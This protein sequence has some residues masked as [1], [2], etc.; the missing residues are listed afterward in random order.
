MCNVCFL[1]FIACLFYHCSQLHTFFNWPLEIKDLW[2]ILKVIKNFLKVIE[3]FTFYCGYEKQRFTASRLALC[4]IIIALLFD[5]QES[6]RF[7]SFIRSEHP[8]FFAK[9]RT[10]S[11]TTL[12]ALI[13]QKVLCFWQVLWW[14]DPLP[15]NG[16]FVKSSKFIKNSGAYLVL[17]ICQWKFLLFLVE[18]L[19]NFEKSEWQLKVQNFN[20][21]L[22]S[23]I[24]QLERKLL[25]FEV[26]S[27]FVEVSAVHWISQG[28]FCP[29][30]YTFTV[31]ELSQNLYKVDKVNRANSAFSS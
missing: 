28:S 6:H 30:W 22:G 26:H 3:T 9:K 29:I 1:L 18:N 20:F 16:I 15:S 4:E 27:I 19:Q 24:A 14:V 2:R 25:R 13:M 12:L 21:F 10:K 5:L 11:L 17:H 23:L 7:P 8:S 31:M